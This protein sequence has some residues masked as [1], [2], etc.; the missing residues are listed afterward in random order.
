MGFIGSTT[1][2]VGY[3]KSFGV[4][5]SVE[6]MSINN[7]GDIIKVLESYPVM[8][9]KMKVQHFHLSLVNRFPALCYTGPVRLDH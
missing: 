7:I 8:K 1:L 3:R 9:I 4:Q 6:V 2:N 5:L